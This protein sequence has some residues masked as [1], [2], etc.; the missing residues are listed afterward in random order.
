VSDETPVAVAAASK[1]AV[2]MS[3]TDDDCTAA[4]DDFEC[5]VYVTF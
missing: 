4:G 1:L 5:I 3:G 2:K